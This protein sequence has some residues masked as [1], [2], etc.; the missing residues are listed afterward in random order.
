MASEYEK[1]PALFGLYLD[2]KNL[3]LPKKFV[4]ISCGNAKMFE[5]LLFRIFSLTKSLLPKI[6]AWKSFLS[7]EKFTENHHLQKQSKR[8]RATF[9]CKRTGPKKAIRLER[10]TKLVFFGRPPLSTV[11][12]NAYHLADLSK[13]DFY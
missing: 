7:Q 8:F 3:L 12:D 2:S 4:P 1:C 6:S 13:I 11:N 9:F 10:P 5:N